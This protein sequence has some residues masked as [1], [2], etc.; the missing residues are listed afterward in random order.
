MTYIFSNHK[1]H[2]DMP[3]NKPICERLFK[4]QNRTGRMK[5]VFTIFVGSL[6][7]SAC[8][9]RYL[10]VQSLGNEL[11]NQEQS[12]EED[13]GLAREASAF[14]LKLAESL[15]KESPGNLKLAQAV[16]AGLTQYTFAYVAFEAEKLAASDST[17]AYRI[18]ER[19]KR[20]YW[21][22]HKHAMLAL[23]LSAPGFQKKLA[24]PDEKNWP[25][26]TKQQI[27]VAYWAA[28]SWGGYISLSKDVPDVI[29]DLPLAYRLAKL[30]WMV[31]PEYAEGGLVSLMGT[32]ESSMPGGSLIQAS[33]YFDSA[34]SVSG[35]KSAGAFVAKAEG[36][37]Q[38]QKD[39]QAYELLLKKA[40]EVSDLHLSLANEAMRGRAQWLLKTADD[41]F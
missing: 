35:G 12:V 16:C 6:L 25:K 9:P 5:N 41:I 34:I 3:V 18:N 33:K 27:G 28:A 20:L 38:A 31:E 4:S 1:K 30:A 32:F 8:S 14:Y 40:I 19:A 15:L 36:I 37:A 22:S 26:L 11:A 29:A 24:S 17:A 10:I 39:R 13:E 7:I 2:R 23:E 21:R